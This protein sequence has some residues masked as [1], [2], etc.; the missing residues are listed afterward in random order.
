MDDLVDALLEGQSIP[1]GLLRRVVETSGGNPFFLSELI[2]SLVASGALASDAGSREATVELPNTIEKVILAR[3]DLQEPSARDLI[4]A[5]S[6]LGRAVELP[7]LE[8]L[9]GSD[10]RAEAD[11][12]VSAG[13]FERDG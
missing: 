9:V 1:G 2:R 5:A 8:R 4:T 10:P 7:L 13:L 3:L 12:L 6:V 11:G